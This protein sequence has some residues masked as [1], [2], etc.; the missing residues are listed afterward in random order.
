MAVMLAAFYAEE[1][2]RGRRAWE[3]Y[4][5]GIEGRGESLDVRFYVTKA[6]PDEENFLATPFLKALFR[7][8]AR[9]PISDDILTND[10]WRRANANIGGTYNG[11]DKMHRHFTDLV[12]WQ[13][14]YEALHGGPLTFRQSFE[15]TNT[16]LAARAAAAPEVLEGMEPDAA[17]FAELRTASTREY[18]V[19]PVAYDLENPT[20]N[21]V[22]H[23]SGIRDLCVRLSLETCAELAGGLSDKALADLKLMVSLADSYKSEPY[24]ISYLVRLSCY[25]TMTQ[26]VWEGL[27]E[28]R[29]TDAQLQELQTRFLACDFVGDLEHTLKGDRPWGVLEYDRLKKEGLGFVADMMPHTSSSAKPL[30]KRLFQWLGSVMP[31]GWYDFEKVNYCRQYEEQF[32]GF[33]DFSAKTISPR[34]APAEIMGA[35]DPFRGSILEAA[36]HHRLF[37]ATLSGLSRS[38]FNASRCQTCMDQMALACALER[39]RLTKGQFPKTLDELTPR[40]IARQ[41]NDVITGKPYK[42]RLTANG[43]FVLYSVGWNEK[44]DGG[45][46][47]KELF[48]K[49]QGDWVW[50]YPAE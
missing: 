28:R 5:A 26:P 9:Q 23:L 45:V 13:Q 6:V 10:L 24:L 35:A 44:D 8:N 27:A 37:A 30:S 38:A 43:Q 50:E 1:D 4:R 34:H 21:L 18:A 29:W 16:S 39:Y 25:Q 19:C 36:L 17:V 3:Q 7:T 20:A 22:P 2:W 31:A 47:G 15:T 33:V 49:T 46:P 12:A 32:K 42:Y 40:F 41:P 48:D 11:K 14:A